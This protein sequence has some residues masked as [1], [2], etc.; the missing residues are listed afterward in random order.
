M[1]EMIFTIIFIYLLYYIWIAFNFDKRGEQKLRGKKKKNNIKIDKKKMPSE[2]QFFVIKYNIDLDKVN[3]RYFLQLMGLV[4]AFDLSIVITIMEFIKILW[5]KLIVAFVLM[6][7][8]VLLSFHFLGRY[9]KKKGLTKDEN[10]KR[11]R[12]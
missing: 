9:F 8:I 1:L 4:V 2:V 7:V 11:N 10:K 5:I 6:I 3:Y 12:K